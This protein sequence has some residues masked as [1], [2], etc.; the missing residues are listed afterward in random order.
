MRALC[1]A[2]LRA[3]RCGYFEPMSLNPK[4][5]RFVEE[6]LI[7]LN[8]TAAYRRAGYVATGNSAEVN[9]ARLL[10]NAQVAAAVAA[11]KELRSDEAKIDAAYVLRQA[12]KLHERCMQEVV[13]VIDRKGEHVQDDE[14][15][16]L[17]AFNAT[18]A[19]KALDL[20]GKHVDVQAFKERMDVNVTGE[21]ADVIAKRRRRIANGKS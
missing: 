4:Q 19:A 3:V 16:P 15:H 8:A 14:G 10:R 12:V 13:P 20:V 21:L 17:Y 5:Q 1:S 6:Y 9:A 18:G 7:D 11:A 2:S